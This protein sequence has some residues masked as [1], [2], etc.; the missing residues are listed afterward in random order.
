MV[1]V[2][3]L[4][5]P[6]KLPYGQGYSIVE[7]QSPYGYVLDSTPVYF[8]VTEEN[9]SEESGVTVIKVEKTNM[10]QKGTISIE[11]T[12]EVFFGVLVSGG[13]DENGQE[14]PVI[15]QPIYETQGLPDTVY[16]IRAAEDVV[17]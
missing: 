5:T 11:K 10:P 6:E 1:V 17:P 14:L 8:D 9:S 16:E 12:V 13:T 3:S 7:V 2:R 4:V 15:Y